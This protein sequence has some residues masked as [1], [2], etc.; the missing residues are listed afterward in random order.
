MSPELQDSSA[1]QNTAKNK[2]QLEDDDLELD[3]R[4]SKKLCTN[5]EESVETTQ[6]VS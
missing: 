4:L 5:L 1:L 6:L 2:R 3:D